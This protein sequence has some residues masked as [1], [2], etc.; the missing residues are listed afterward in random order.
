M[1][2]LDR[3]YLGIAKLFPAKYK[4]H[5]KQLTIYAGEQF[6]VDIY[7]GKWSIIALLGFIAASLVPT[8]FSQEFA[9][10]YLGFS[11][12]VFLL[13]EA[14]SYL[15]IYFKAEDRTK[16]VEAVLPDALQLIGAN[17]RAGMTPFKALK[18]AARKE[19]GPLQDEINHVTARALGTE[20]FS[21]IMLKMSDRIR[22]ELLRRAVEL[23]TTAMRSGGHL[24]TVLEEL[25]K[26]IDETRSLKRELVTNTKMYISL[27]MFS[28]ILGAPMLLAIS[29]QFT[30]IISDMQTSSGVSDVGFGMG[31]LA[32]E[33]AITADFLTKIAGGMLILTSLLASMLLG[34]IQEGKPQYGFRYAPPI[35][36]GTFIAFVIF[37]VVIASFFGSMM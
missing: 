35:V 23:F 12:L 31:F 10:K 9:F 26:D 8:A 4:I 11:F 5:F 1:N 18:L 3:F 36:I 21:D 25:A 22:S 2:L 29:I 7:L 32:G 19:F 17:V 14:T 33:I 20:S 6:N 24:A 37:R 13:V 15:I 27:I 16:R 28:V 30:E 34:S